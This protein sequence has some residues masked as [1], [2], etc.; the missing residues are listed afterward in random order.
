MR[1]LI[2][3]LVLFSALVTLPVKPPQKKKP[4]PVAPD[5][6]R[7]EVNQRIKKVLFASGR[8]WILALDGTLTTIDLKRGEPEVVAPEKLV[9]DIYRSSSGDLYILSAASETSTVMHIWQQAP[10]S[11]TDEAEIRRATNDAVLG[12]KEYRNRLLV[13]TQHKIYLRDDNAQ[14]RTVTIK[15][16]LGGAYQTPFA[17]TDSGYIYLGL[18]HGEFGGG[19]L[20][21]SIDSGQVRKLEKRDKPDLCAGPLNS[22]CDPV[23]GVI[24]DPADPSCVIASI[25]LRHF[26]ESGRLIRVCNES[27]SVV[28]SK[29]FREI[30]AEDKVESADKVSLDH[31]T[32]AIFD[33]V[34]G[35]KDYWAVTGR[36]VYR[37]TPGEAPTFHAMPKLRTLAGITL[38]DDITNV[39]VVSTDI[40]WAASLSGYT[41]LLAVKN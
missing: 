30:A 35:E 22:E 3:S 33:L 14:W 17:A 18:N 8:L 27:V 39:I 1:Q 2:L 9:L 6:T 19:L 38:S 25:G 23:T 5:P 16:G 24:R 31:A 7:V 12:L 29:S 36:G 21:V 20:Q 32:E 10:T 37:F 26:M 15:P 4:K 34:P 41:P 13:L 11:W 28:F 40:N